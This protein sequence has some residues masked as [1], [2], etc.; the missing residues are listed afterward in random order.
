V[1]VGWE[2]WVGLVSW[3]G[4]GGWGAQSAT[5]CGE[6]VD[7]FSKRRLRGVFSHR[8]ITTK[9][10]LICVKNVNRQFVINYFYIFVVCNKQNCYDYNPT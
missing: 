5:A 6:N 1:D 3:A 2:R 9:T 7:F 8:P 10:V 4:C